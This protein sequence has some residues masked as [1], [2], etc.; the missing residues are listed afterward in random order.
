MIWTRATLPRIRY[1]RLMAF[2]WKILLPLALMVIFFTAVGIVLEMLWLIPVI[3][4]VG[5]LVVATL[6]TRIGQSSSNRIS[7]DRLESSIQRR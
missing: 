6:T 3:S 4:I 5:F 2:G 7:R 1:D